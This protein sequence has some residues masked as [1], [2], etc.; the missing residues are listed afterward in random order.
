MVGHIKSWIINVYAGSG[1]WFFVPHISDFFRF[2]LFNDNIIAG[3]GVHVNGGCRRAHI[4]WHIVAF[5]GESGHGGADLVGGVTISG[6]P[7]T[8]H[9]Y[10][11]DLTLAHEGSRHVI[12][13]QSDVQTGA[14]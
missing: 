2:S 8:A 3:G 11:L 6:H 5:G 7:V 12:A 10:S 1:H 13:Q 9:K 14:L 4:K